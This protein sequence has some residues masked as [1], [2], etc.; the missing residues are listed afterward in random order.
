MQF[1]NRQPEIWRP[2]TGMP[3]GAHGWLVPGHAELSE[4]WA[5][6]R[7][8]LKNRDEPR[9]FLDK[10]LEERGRAF[11][12]ETG[13]IE[14]LY[15]LKAGITEQL[16]AEGLEG[17]VHSHTVEN[18]EDR[19]IKGLL[20]DQETAYTMLFEDIASGRPLTQ[21]AV[22]SWHQLVT[23]HQ[24]TVAGL[25][26]DGRRAQVA[27]HRKG[28]WKNRPNNPRR[29]DG[30]VHEYCP[31]EVVQDE[32]DRF[33]ALH[34]KIQAERYPVYVEAAWMHHRFVRTHPFQDGNGRVSR[35]L[36]AYAYIRR[37]EPPPII[38]AAGREDYI[39]AL[40]D[41]DGG[42]L[43]AFSDYLGRLA[44][45]TLGAAVSLG[46]RALAG[47]MNRPNGNGGRTVGTTYMPPVDE[48]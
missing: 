48:G 47:N 40:E 10:W 24:E 37:G 19:T 28:V 34:G 32:M 43:K 18:V 9:A 12:I 39:N 29:L 20:A 23:R 45:V 17:V 3:D 14:G 44:L 15:T 7:A 26:A 33:F 30:V 21:H 11:A 25:A 31:P 1:P 35:M 38:A 46:Q 4:E 22:K 27:F 6:I 8:S 2:L 36:M 13:Q 5:A 41:A 42:D 16:I